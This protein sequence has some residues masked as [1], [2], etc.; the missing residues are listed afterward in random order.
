MR[1]AEKTEQS[2]HELIRALEVL[3]NK[4]ESDRKLFAADLQC[5]LDDE[6]FS[7]FSEVM[8]GGH[9]AAG[10]SAD[11]AA[12]TL[13][14]Y[15]FSQCLKDETMAESVAAAYTIATGTPHPIV[16]HVTGAFHSDY[17][18]GTA[19]RV[20]RRLPGKRVVVLSMRPVTDLDTL[21]PDADDRR[22]GQYIVY[23][24]G[25]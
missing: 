5:P 15:Y 22:A 12:T 18:Q 13:Q 2:L 25:K 10:A 23:T 11:E 8:G 1:L 14:R 4:S 17:G 21:A 24:I 6:Y 16:A 20:R 7:R 19:A 3:Q 9:P